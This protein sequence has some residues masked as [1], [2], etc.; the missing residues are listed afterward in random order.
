MTIWHGE[1]WM[2]PIKTN[3]IL[4]GANNGILW[5]IYGS[6]EWVLVKLLNTGL[7]ISSMHLLC[8]MSWGY[9]NFWNKY[10]LKN[11]PQKNS[12]CINLLTEYKQLLRI[13]PCKAIAPSCVYEH[14][15]ERNFFVIILIM[16]QCG[17]SLGHICLW[18]CGAT[19]SS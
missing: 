6:Q 4:K 3:L 15:I 11:L 14:D 18:Q 8:A 12:I 9:Y 16:T 1:L 19:I 10:V 7:R 2:A 5:K 17:L 13:G